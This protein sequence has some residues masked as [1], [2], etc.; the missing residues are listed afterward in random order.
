MS[1][2]VLANDLSEVIAADHLG[3]VLKPVRDDL[4]ST[5]ATT[6]GSGL[7]GGDEAVNDAGQGTAVRGRAGR[8]I[9]ISSAYSP[10]AWPPVDCNRR[11]GVRSAVAV[12]S[13]FSAAIDAVR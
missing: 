7:R 5:D 10:R 4:A 13:F 3:Q 2:P 11:S 6:A 9:R 12:T 8:E 1:G